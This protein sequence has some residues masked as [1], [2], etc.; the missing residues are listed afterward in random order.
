MDSFSLFNNRTLVCGKSKSGKSCL[1]KYLLA[2]DKS[3]FDK[4]FVI[5]GT[6]DCNGFYSSFIDSKCIFTEYKEEWI[7]D[8]IK[9]LR[10]YKVKNGKT[11]N[12][13]LI[14]DDL[15]SDR[16]FNKS[17]SLSI[18]ACQGR[19][20]GLSF[21][22][23]LQHIPQVPPVI[24]NNVNYFIVG[25]SNQHT[26]EILV[27]SFRFGDID[28]NEFLKMYH[29]ATSNYGFLVIVC[30]SVKNPHDLNSIYGIIR[31]PPKYIN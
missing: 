12:T 25:Q 7:K 4:V 9:M 10:D 16:N 6:E 14:L 11:Y 20:Y 5:S 19:H 22:C 21:C 17:V 2:R 13:L 15:G 23:L 8:L 1:L 29:K 24:R 27:D 31:S 30:D 28:R 26:A 18:I 3:K